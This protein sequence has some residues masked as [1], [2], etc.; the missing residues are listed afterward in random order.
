MI[1]PSAASSGI[2]FKN[3]YSVI[4]STAAEEKK[5]LN[6]KKKIALFNY[7]ADKSNGLLVRFKYEQI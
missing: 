3:N 4:T 1:F 5:I 6:K 7:D 2:P